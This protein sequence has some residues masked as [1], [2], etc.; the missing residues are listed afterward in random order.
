MLRDLID[1]RKIYL[2]LLLLAFLVA[3]LN[4]DYFIT[5]QKENGDFAVN[6]MSIERAASFEQYTG[7]YSR[8]GFNHP[9]PTN[10]YLFVLAERVFFFLPE[11]YPAHLLAQLI[12]NF[13]FLFS[14]LWLFRKI[15]RLP[16]YTYLFAALLFLLMT[17]PGDMILASI[18]GPDI[19]IL[20][21]LLF[22]LAVQAIATL[23]HPAFISLSISAIFIVHNHA[24]GIAFVAPLAIYAVIRHYY[25]QKKQGHSLVPFLRQITV[26]IV[27]LILFNILPLYEQFTHQPGNI[28]RILTYVGENDSWRKFDQSLLFTLDF[29]GEVFTKFLLLPSKALGGIVFVLFFVAWKKEKHRFYRHLAALL[30][31]F[32][33]ITLYSVL[34]V[35]GDLLKHP[36]HYLYSVV[37][38][39]LF[40]TLRR[41]IAAAAR[42]IPASVRERSYILSVVVILLLALFLY[43]ADPVKPD[44]FP[45]V[46]FKNT[47]LSDPGEKVY[48]FYW[49]FDERNLGQ[50]GIA[51]GAMLEM[52]RN[53][54]DVCVNQ[55][56]TFV[57]GE[58]KSCDNY[59]DFE[60]IRFE[61][62]EWSDEL[63][64]VEPGVYEFQWTRWFVE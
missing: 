55:E 28:S 15:T 9:G 10:F 1:G 39:Q 45:E 36:Y 29:Y 16:S 8:M 64:E 38:L 30:F 26:S 40:F 32:F 41:P 14:I 23:R 53:G 17:V 58:R 61:T 25:L 27:L 60:T 56:W 18:W 52:I 2:P 3:G 11:H 49:E 42:K 48:R 63:L 34:K 5:P 24:S 4:Y 31:V 33:I 59:S 54:Y 22:L 62:I 50:W 44:P 35:P 51:A 47:N 6:A 21:T 13:L 7:A 57:F 19:I 20:P 12:L 37:A 46:F 43:N